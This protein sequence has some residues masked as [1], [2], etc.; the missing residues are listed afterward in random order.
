MFT[1][2]NMLKMSLVK[3]RVGFNIFKTPHLSTPASIASVSCRNIR[4]T[5]HQDDRRKGNLNDMF[6]KF[7]QITEKFVSKLPYPAQK[8]FYA[9][10]AGLRVQQ[11]QFRYWRSAQAKKK[12]DPHSYITYREEMAIYLLKK[13]FLKTAWIV[14]T[15]LFVPFGLFLIFI[16]VFLIPRY[17]LPDCYWTRDQ[18]SK[19]LTQLATSR[20]AEYGMILHHLSYH[21]DNLISQ[22]RAKQRLHALVQQVSEGGVPSV[23]SILHLLPLFRDSSSLLRISDLPN[24]VLRSLCNTAFIVPFQTKSMAIRSLTRSMDFIF[25]LD[26]KLRDEDLLHKLSPLHLEYATLMRGLDS[27]SLSPDANRYFLQHWLQV[28]RN[29]SADDTVF[30]LHAMVLMSFNYSETKFKRKCFG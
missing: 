18:R 9:F 21:K 30:M 16:P 24:P 23:D 14:P 5:P 2:M 4:M 10:S 19:Y 15:F 8:S 22:D 29:C 3:N 11:K 20:T 6:E 27:L 12:I 1:T 7:N 13:D 26:R 28:T 25:R 17:V